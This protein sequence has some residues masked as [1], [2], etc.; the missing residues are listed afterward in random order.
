MGVRA[1]AYA[2]VSAEEVL[3]GARFDLTIA[4]Q[5]AT[6]RSTI[7]ERNWELASENYDWAVPTSRPP[8]K[9]PALAS[10]LSA[11]DEG[12]ADVLVVAR[13]DRISTRVQAWTE[14]VDRSIGQR[15]ALAVVEEGFEISPDNT[16]AV[17]ELFATLVQRDRLRRAARSRAGSAAAKARGMRLGRPTEHP[18]A[19]RNRVKEL[20]ERGATLTEIAE[21]FNSRGEPT[22]RG[23]RWRIGTVQ[24]VLATI[25]LDSERLDAEAGARTVEAV[26]GAARPAEASV[27][28]KALREGDTPARRKIVTTRMEG[29]RHTFDYATGKMQSE[30]LG[31]PVEILV[32]RVVREQDAEG[33]LRPGEP[34][35]PDQEYVKVT[36]FSEESE[37]ELADRPTF[38][39]TVPPVVIKIAE[40]D[41]GG[42]SGSGNFVLPG[43]DYD[44]LMALLDKPEELL[45]KPAATRD[46]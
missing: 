24:S 26:G 7:D 40:M 28:E 4:A 34:S 11:L 44:R 42:L 9:R 46:L 36:A 18:P 30:E 33:D 1:V 32:T 37:R 38:E 29:T 16:E 21:D 3:D 5:L 25:R 13:L 31:E 23:K 20:R 22:P 14:L 8:E 17:P 35:R 10:A 27:V 12:Y 19:V 41:A 2:N 6:A 43:P 39:I 45:W 15:W